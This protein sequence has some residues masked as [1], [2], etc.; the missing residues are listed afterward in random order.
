MKKRVY[1][2]TIFCAIL[3]LMWGPESFAKYVLQDKLD[4][5]IYIDKTPPQI[6]LVCEGK[7]ESFLSSNVEDTQKRS[8]NVGIVTSDNVEIEK[9]E[10]YFNTVGPNFGGMISKEFTS[11]QVFS[12]E[13]FY[14]IVASDI[15]GNKTEIIVLI[16]KSAPEVTLK[17]FKKSEE[18]AT[19]KIVGKSNNWASSNIVNKNHQQVEKKIENENIIPEE[20]GGKNELTEQENTIQNQVNFVENIVTENEIENKV[21]TEEAESQM[22]KNTLQEQEKTQELPEN[23]VQ[24]FIEPE[25]EKTS[26][27][28]KEPVEMSEQILKQAAEEN[29]VEL[30]QELEISSVQENQVMLMA[31]SDAFVGNEAEFRQALANQAS[32]IHVRQSIDFTSPIYINYPITIV[33]EGASNSL[34]Y[35]NPGSFIVVQNGGELVLNSMVVDTK[36]SGVSGITAINIQSGG[37]VTFICSSIVDG[38]SRKYRNSRE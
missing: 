1:I 15:S 23:T 38:G 30:P 5:H 33:A 17:Y 36:S 27:V 7:T 4:L 29:F 13:G 6:E 31:I 11:G 37:Y 24:E 22:S 21:E 14:K 26:Q 10:Y 25:E 19:R 2:V 35:A 20:E 28:E 3:I 9:N 16:D 18:I 34:R 12:E 32:V 8:C